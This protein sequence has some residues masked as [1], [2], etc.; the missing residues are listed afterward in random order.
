MAARSGIRRHLER[1]ES[2]MK[3]TDVIKNAL[4]STQS[5]LEMYLADLSD[6]DL[7]HRPVPKANTIAWQLGHLVEAEIG[8]GG[9]VPG[10][11]YPDVPA[12]MEM[13][14]DGSDPPG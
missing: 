14:K 1:Q 2:T 11:K 5:L 13:A 6:A 12:N 3:G 7:R 9:A 10:A 4:E 8:L